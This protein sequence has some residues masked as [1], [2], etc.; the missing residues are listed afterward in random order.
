[1]KM[2][3]EI[4]PSLKPSAEHGMID[5]FGSLETPDQKHP[6]EIAI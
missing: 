1:M 3:E 2:I 5:P 6:D 4:K